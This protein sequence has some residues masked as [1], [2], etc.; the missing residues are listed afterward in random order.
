MKSIMLLAVIATL[1]QGGC[2]SFRRNR[3]VEVVVPPHDTV[4]RDQSPAEGGRKI[5]VVRQY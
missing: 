1:L 2:S 3:E 5:P 4:V